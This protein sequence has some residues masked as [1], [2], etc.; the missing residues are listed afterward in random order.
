M[1]ELYEA[2]AGESGPQVTELIS[3]EAA[4]LILP[5]DYAWYHRKP[6]EEGIYRT[7]PSF[8]QEG[9][10]YV[11]PFGQQIVG[12]VPWQSMETG[13]EAVQWLPV[14]AWLAKVGKVS[15]L[16]GK[17]AELAERLGAAGKETLLSEGGFLSRPKGLTMGKKIKVE[18]VV[19]ESKPLSKAELIKNKEI[20]DL[21]KSEVNKYIPGIGKGAGSR[22]GGG[23]LDLLKSEKG[24]V[25]IDISK[26]GKPSF[27]GKSAKEVLGP[28]LLEEIKE[29]GLT[30][31][32]RAKILARYA[33]TPERKELVSSIIGD[34]E[35]LREAAGPG[36]RGYAGGSFASTKPSP[37]DL[38]LFIRITQETP[39]NIENL[40]TDIYKKTGK[41][42][43]PLL[44]GNVGSIRN[45]ITGRK[46]PSTM[47]LWNWEMQKRYPGADLVRLWQLGLIPAGA[48][49]MAYLNSV[50]GE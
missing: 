43:H 11:V 24:A 27:P 8:L 23:W 28:K 32:I 1:A 20:N 34:I 41:R 26:G 49:L 50:Q 21:I 4:Q 45:P 7:P 25:G 17:S 35:R 12:E 48:G 22:P 46:M 10:K 31:E 39:L 13:M 42:L 9:G 47:Q 18:P 3:P 19:I 37:S 16:L 6:G 33:T 29:K 44:L 30:P 36:S 14:L 15:S 5:E 40:A 38:D 2:L